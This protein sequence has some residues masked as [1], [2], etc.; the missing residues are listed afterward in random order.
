VTE[1]AIRDPFKDPRPGDVVRI[2]PAW[3]R[4]VREANKSF[5]TFDAC[6]NGYWENNCVLTLS[7]WRRSMLPESEVLHVAE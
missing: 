7:G 1:A 4:H 5:V 2:K 3:E 6:V